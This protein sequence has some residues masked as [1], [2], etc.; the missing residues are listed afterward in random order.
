M[1]VQTPSQSCLLSPVAAVLGLIIV[2]V[3]SSIQNHMHNT[4]SAIYL[5]DYLNLGLATLQDNWQQFFVV[6]CFAQG[7]FALK[8]ILS[9][10]HHLMTGPQSG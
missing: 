10:H 5:Y 8:Y 9:H 2:I 6:P 4:N 3:N 7:L 1:P